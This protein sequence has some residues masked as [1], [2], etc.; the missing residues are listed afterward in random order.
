MSTCTG[1]GCDDMHACTMPDGSPCR[2]LVEFDDGT[3]ICSDC[4]AEYE[5]FQ[6][7]EAQWPAEARPSSDLILPGDQEYEQTVCGLPCMLRQC[8]K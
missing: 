1:C 5:E 2:W 4:P 6:R 8:G 3:G 7:C